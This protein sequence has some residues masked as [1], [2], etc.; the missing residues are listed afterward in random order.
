[1]RQPLGE[2]LSCH[3]GAEAQEASR[4][5]LAV[6]GMGWPLPVPCSRDREVPAV[7]G[8]HWGHPL[9]FAPVTRAQTG[10]CASATRRASLPGSGPKVQ[11]LVWAGHTPAESHSGAAEPVNSPYFSGTV[12][13][14]VVGHAGWLGAGS[15]V[16]EWWTETQVGGHPALSR[17]PAAAPPGALPE[18][19][20]HSYALG[21]ESLTVQEGWPALPESEGRPRG[22]PRGSRG[23]LGSGSRRAEQASF[24]PLGTGTR[25]CRR[26]RCTG[27][28][29]ESRRPL[30][31]GTRWAGPQRGPL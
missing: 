27:S 28:Q 31:A 7:S 1:M 26:G 21:D 8:G 17:S 6:E 16:P 18:T 29:Q 5:G 10:L 20:S 3:R 30:W 23:V 13:E 15:G 11:P 24:S 14:W 22:A 19:T 25:S 2:P 4:P 9:I 12:G